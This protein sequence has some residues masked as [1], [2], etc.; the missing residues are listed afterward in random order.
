[1]LSLLGDSVDVRYTGLDDGLCAPYEAGK[2]W[3][4]QNWDENPEV[5]VMKFTWDIS[6][7]GVFSAIG[8]DGDSDFETRDFSKTRPQHLRV[9]QS[10][11]HKTNNLTWYPCDL[12][13]ISDVRYTGL[14]D[15]LSPLDCLARFL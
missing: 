11:G 2:P 3:Q 10:W 13:S 14:D 12:I 8:R 15:G 5:P 4:V 7:W 1:M 6:K 9:N